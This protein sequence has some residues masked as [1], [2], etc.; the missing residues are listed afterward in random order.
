MSDQFAAHLL[1][2]TDD[3]L[4]PGRQYLLKLGTATVP[5]TVSALKHKVDVNSLEHMAARTLALNEVGY[6]NFSL[7]QP[8]AFDPYR[9][10]RDTGG[11]IIDAADLPGGITV[12]G[13]PGT[14][15]IFDFQEGVIELRHGAGAFV[16]TTARGKK[17]TDN[18]R[19]GQTIVSAAVERLRARGVTDEEIRRLFE[20]ALAGSNKTG[21]HGE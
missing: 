20:A 14:N 19:D 10:N 17:L 8:L 9:D 15:R 2:M 3:E 5:A 11:L 18:M 21:G 12:D 1:W 13:G 6:C 4:L 7:A 16:S